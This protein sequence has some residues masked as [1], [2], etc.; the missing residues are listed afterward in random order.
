[1]Q[2]W[3]HC[4]KS[5]LVVALSAA[6]AG[7]LTDG[8]QPGDKPQTRAEAWRFLSQASFGPDEL[9][10]QRVTDIGY[11]A[12]IDEQFATTPTLTYRAFVDQR[13]AELKADALGGSAKIAPAQIL[14]AFYT[15]ALADKAQLRSRLA[16]ALSEIFVVS[17]SSDTLSARAP[18][19]VAGHMD[20]LEAGLDGNYRQLLEAI[21]RDPAMGEYL[22]FRSNLKEMPSAGHFPDENFAREIMQLF[23]IGLYELNQD[24]SLR[25][26]ANGKPIETYTSDDV[27]GLAKVFTGWGNYR[28]AAYAGIDDSACFWWADQC[29]DPEGYY[30]PMVSYPAYHSTSEKVFLGVTV[31]AQGTPD[32]ETSLRIA[33]DRLASHANTAPFFSKQLIQRLVSSNPSPDYVA[34]VAARFTASGG[35][36]KETVKAVLLDEEARGPISLLAPDS[37]KLREPV[38]RVTAILRAFGFKAPT[39]QVSRSVL[40]SGTAAQR[41]PYVTLGLTSDPATSLGQ[42]PLYAPSV[43]NFFRPGYT[44]PQSSSSAKMLVEPEM[45]LVSE[46]SVTGYVNVMTDLLSNGMGP[47]VVADADGQCGIFT[48]QVQQYIQ[49]LDAK[50]A[51][52]KA[53]QTAAASCQLDTL[54]QRAVTP[55]LTVQRSFAYDPNQLAQHI[56]DRLLG[57]DMT[58]TLR[59]AVVTAT[60]A[61]AVPALNAAQSNGDAINSALDKRVWAAILMVAVSPEFLVTK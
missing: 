32:P 13:A 23:S 11:E 6:L 51:A 50:V 49:S 3:A 19:M 29:H 60:Q 21:A 24:G 18:E 35:N 55:Q 40:D 46:S 8:S 42:T 9:S 45:Q 10:I 25:L 27:K 31:P 28:G 57:G 47:T 22:T 14:E 58:P 4:F 37:G 52:N 30:H 43:F 5:V 34:R 39:L 33:L 59:Q 7:C 41:T 48:P 38:L 26:G 20:T 15:R 1:M 17:F 16:F 61:L 54:T 44:A 36:I 56:A 2:R 53:L 12:W